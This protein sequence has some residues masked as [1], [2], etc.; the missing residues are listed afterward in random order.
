[1]RYLRLLLIPL[2]GLLV[3]GATSGC[4]STKKKKYDQAVVRLLLEADQANAGAVVRLPQSGLVIPVEPK[5]HFTEYDIEACEVVDNE[6]GKSLVFRFTS[7]AGR[8]L[9]RLSVPNQGKRII[10]TI[11]GQPV[12]ARRIERPLAQGV[13]VTYVELPTEVNLEKLARDI[14]RTSQDMREELEKTQK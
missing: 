8:D 11:N 2:L 7:Q 12:G 1:M 4:M 10:T 6:L 14:T 13:F 5:A 3:L 9:F